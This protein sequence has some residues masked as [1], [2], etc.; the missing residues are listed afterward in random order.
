M[1]QGSEV[2]FQCSNLQSVR[3]HGFLQQ[4]WLSLNTRLYLEGSDMHECQRGRIRLSKKPSAPS[5]VLQGV[6]D[7][8]GTPGAPLVL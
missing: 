4:E 7:R 1:S 2:Y 6:Q 5:S 8:L 3:P